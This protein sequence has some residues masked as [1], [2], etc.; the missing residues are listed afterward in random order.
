MNNQQLEEEN[1]ELKKIIDTLITMN[2]TT[3]SD[4]NQSLKVQEEMLENLKK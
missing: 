3:L 1:K 2:R 4:I